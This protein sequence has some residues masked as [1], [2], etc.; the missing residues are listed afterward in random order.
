MFGDCGEVGEEVIELV[1]VDEWLIY[2]GCLFGEDFLS[3]FFCVDEEDCVVVG[4]GFFDEV[5]GFVDVVQ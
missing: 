1:L 3:L 4:D 2:V 5:V